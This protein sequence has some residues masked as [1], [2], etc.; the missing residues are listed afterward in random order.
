MSE[1]NSSRLYEIYAYA[2]E[3]LAE[4]ELIQL[5]TKS[6]NTFTN[7]QEKKEKTFK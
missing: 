7:H 1:F 6:Q 3:S 4:G 5:F 2:M